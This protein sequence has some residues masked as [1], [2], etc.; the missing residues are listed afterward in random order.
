MQNLNDEDKK[1]P[2]K[3]YEKNCFILAKIAHK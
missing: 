3:Q 2:N 1:K